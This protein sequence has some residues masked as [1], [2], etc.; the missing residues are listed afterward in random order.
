[1]GAFVSHFE[2]LIYFAGSK[3]RWSCRI[4]DSEI[5]ARVR[6][7][8]RWLTR[9]YTLNI[10]GSLDA[11]RCGYVLLRDGECVEQYDPPLAE[12]RST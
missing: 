8:W 7:P 12:V 4:D 3:S 2:G 11:T 9:L 1:M 5:I 6:T 10:H